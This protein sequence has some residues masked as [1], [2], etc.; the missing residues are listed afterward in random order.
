MFEAA[1]RHRAAQR[2]KPGN[3]RTLKPFRWWQPLDRALFALSLDGTAG[4]LLVYTV[5]VSAGRRLLS[6]DGKGKADLYLDGVHHAESKPN[7]K[8]MRAWST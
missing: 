3:G 2:V 6:E 4:Q 5:D 7:Q 8:Q 1:K